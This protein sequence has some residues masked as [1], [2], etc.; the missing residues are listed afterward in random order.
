MAESQYEKY[1]V[2]K[3]NYEAGPG[4]KNRQSPTMSFMSTKQVTRS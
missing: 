2:R 3:P 4:V 1:V